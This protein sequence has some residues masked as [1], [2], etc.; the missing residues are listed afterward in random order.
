MV[1]CGEKV[2]SSHSLLLVSGHTG[3][4]MDSRFKTTSR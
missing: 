1:A 2:G 4:I 3:E